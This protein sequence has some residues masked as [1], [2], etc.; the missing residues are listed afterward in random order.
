[1]TDDRLGAF[2]APRLDSIPR[3]L[4]AFDQDK[5]TRGTKEVP[6]LQTVRITHIKLL[7]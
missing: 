7:S 4:G 1:M 5:Q 6:A 3:L 2:T